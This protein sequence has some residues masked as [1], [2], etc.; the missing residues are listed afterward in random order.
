M[1]L[2]MLAMIA[3]FVVGCQQPRPPLSPGLAANC[4]D[5]L[6][7]NEHLAWGEATE[8]LPPDGA[9][10]DGNRWWQVRYKPG[11]DGAP[12]LVLVAD[13]TRWVRLP[14]ADWVQRVKA[15]TPSA[16]PAPEKLLAGP[17][18]L[19]VVGSGS[20]PAEQRARRKVDAN[21]LNQLAV[22]TGL[23]PAFTVREQRDGQ[24]QLVYGW[25]GDGG[26]ARDETVRDW[27]R[28]RTRWQ[29]SVWIDL[30]AP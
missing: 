8:I 23:V 14:P 16:S 19:D 6:L 10:A 1:R 4:A 29:T 28:L 21:E 12:R 20:E 22:R 3:V 13:Q 15:D 18:I 2:L 17:W 5:S 30:A 25:Q 11:P 26:M 7:L 9:D 24:V 27:L